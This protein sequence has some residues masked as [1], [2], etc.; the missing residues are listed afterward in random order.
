MYL[1]DTF[2]VIYYSHNYTRTFACADRHQNEGASRHILCLNLNHTYSTAL[3]L[4]SLGFEST[5]FKKVY[6]CSDWILSITTP[7]I[8]QRVL[9]LIAGKCP[10]PTGT[11]LAKQWFL[12]HLYAQSDCMYW[13]C[14]IRFRP[15]PIVKYS[16]G[17]VVFRILKWLCQLELCGEGILWHRRLMADMTSLLDLWHMFQLSLLQIAGHYIINYPPNSQV[18]LLLSCLWFFLTMGHMHKRL[19][20]CACQPILIKHSYWIHFYTKSISTKK[21]PQ[22]YHENRWWAHD[23]AHRRGSLTAGSHKLFLTQILVDYEPSI[24]YGLNS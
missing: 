11:P 20:T 12:G 19:L 7:R 2:S 21:H 16:A 18:L 14:P 6:P 13:S 9:G 22:Y 15:A 3:W 8:P 4:H 10:F 23:L 5:S 17:S 1:E 24:N